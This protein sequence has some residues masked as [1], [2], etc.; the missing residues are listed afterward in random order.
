MISKVHKMIRNRRTL[1]VLAACMI[2]SVLC[3]AP[4]VQESVLRYFR[5]LLNT[6]QEKVYL[7]LDK[8]MYLAGENIWFK[9]YLVSAITHK[10]QDAFSKYIMVEL[11]DRKD[12]LILSKKVKEEDG[13]FYGNLKLDG[14][15]PSGDYYLRSYTNWMRNEEPEFFYSR[16]L[17]INNSVD[18]EI[19]SE[20][21]YEAL[22]SNKIRAL[23]NFKLN[24]EA[25]SRKVKLTY[26][27]CVGE[28][29]LNRGKATTDESGALSLDIPFDRNAKNQRLEILFADD[30]YEYKTTFY[31]YLEDTEYS[32]TFFPEG[33][34]LLPVPNQIVAFKAQ[35]SNGYSLPVSG[36]VMNQSGEEVASLSTMCDGMGAFN[37]SASKGDR[38]YA[39]VTSEDGTKKRFDLP[40]VKPSGIKLVA[41]RTGN[42]IAYQVLKDEE[43]P[44]PDTL[45]VAAH[46]RGLLRYMQIIDAQRT[47][48][49]I[50]D[51]YLR[52]GI[53]HLLLLDKQGKTLSERLVFVK[54]AQQ[55]L[56]DLVPDKPSYGPRERVQLTLTATDNNGSPLNG[57]FGISVTNRDLVPL[58]SLSDN[59]LSNLL[60]TSDLK[61]FVENPGRYFLSSNKR[62][63][64]ELNLLML[65][66]GWR[67]FKC[68]DFTQVPDTAFKYYVEQ[69]LSFTGRVRPLTGSPAGMTVVAMANS[70]GTMLTATTDANGIFV[71]QGADVPDSTQFVV[72]SRGRNN[73]PVT[74]LLDPVE[75]STP[76]NPKLPYPDGVI[77]PQFTEEAL[78]AARDR[79]FAEGGILLR[80]LKEVTVTGK[81][82]QGKV[83][84]PNYMYIR[85]ADRTIGA[86]FLDD[87]RN[88]TA[89]DIM[90]QMPGVTLTNG[91]EGDFFAFQSAS[92]KKP[93]LIIDGVIYQDAAD[94]SLLRSYSGNEIEQI[95][96]IRYN[97]A[98]LAMLGMNGSNGAFVITTR[99]VDP[100]VQGSKANAVLFTPRGYNQSVEFYSPVYSTPTLKAKPELDL[101]S[102]LYWNPR[103]EVDET[104]TARIEYYVDD[105][106]SDHRVVI[107][108]VTADGRPARVE[109]LLKI[110]P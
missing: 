59:I 76:T 86:E 68:D 58:D 18:T 82:S 89:W 38:F 66:H 44:W 31:P 22:G 97:S 74:V 55:P 78:N 42:G 92:S 84:D 51:E 95:S 17:K 36:K 33:G 61:G 24:G 26:A 57:D 30:K 3:S 7:Q 46:I 103:V 19:T 54:R 91:S 88:L 13:L 6:P 73:L 27:V 77:L 79:Y 106:N 99:K 23:V 56:L 70:T 37:L 16:L 71:I 72:R 94:Y 28:N 100:L 10:E 104:G 41:K 14:D 85:M 21:T 90:E 48:D 102:T 109:K 93:L 105:R 107:E 98:A 20:A 39:E 35:G 69:G 47:S 9:G 64:A 4:S 110:N 29:A 81:K 75:F 49:I 45:Y 67:R 62:A 50:G 80:N 96:T 53:A 65:T 25:M 83:S 63:P 15:L 32:V 101:R 43:T 11:V 52:D 60:L 5:L 2:C 8:S 87:R 34:D 40:Q 1:F 12:S 108:G